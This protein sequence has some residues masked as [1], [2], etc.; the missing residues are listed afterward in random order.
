MKIDDFQ[1]Q[2]KNTDQFSDEPEKVLHALLNL[3]ESVGV[4]NRFIEQSHRDKSLPD[5]YARSRISQRLGDILWYVANIATRNGVALSKAAQDNLVRTSERWGKANELRGKQF[6]DAMPV[7]ERIPRK[8]RVAFFEPLSQSRPR[9]IMIAIPSDGGE[10]IQVGDRIDDNADREDGY[11]FHDVL[12]LSNAAHLGWSPV[13]RALLRRKRKSKPEI[14]RVEDGARAIN[15]EEALTAFIFAH[16]VNVNFFEGIKNVD[17]GLLKTVE[18]LT[19]GLEVRHRSYEDWE[20]AILDGYRLFREIRERQEGV[21][22]VDIEASRDRRLMLKELPGSV[23]SDLQAQV[24]A[25]SNSN[26]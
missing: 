12:H 26:A 5:D 11:R 14:D 7:F 24:N 10:W 19:F 4:L 22:E 23:K 8:F 9:K 1:K 18:R 15:I 6:D 2:A 17:F 13:I 25:N 16:A 3:T 21:V 20:I